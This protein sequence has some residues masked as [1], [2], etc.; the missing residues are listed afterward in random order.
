MIHMK[1]Q[2]MRYPYIQ[3]ISYDLTLTFLLFVFTLVSGSLSALRFFLGLAESSLS[4]CL[5]AGRV[6]CAIWSH[7]L[8]I[9]V[10]EP[11]RGDFWKEDLREVHES[12]CHV[13]ERESGM[14][15]FDCRTPAVAS[16]INSF[17]WA[18]LSLGFSVQD[19]VASSNNR[20]R[21]DDMNSATAGGFSS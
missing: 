17:S 9:A 19:C 5:V 20:R 3:Q 11:K 21:S 4:L 18:A 7:C 15:R 2:Y 16:F 10:D 8:C 14:T 13:S 1:S 6:S 12:G